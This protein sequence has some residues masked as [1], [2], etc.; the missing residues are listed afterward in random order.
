MK[1]GF[2]WLPVLLSTVP[3]CD[4]KMAA[5]PPFISFALTERI[6]EKSDRQKGTY[7]IIIV[8]ILFVHSSFSRSPA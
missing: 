5:M 3:N 8:N 6:M 2:F 4:H 1:P 7:K